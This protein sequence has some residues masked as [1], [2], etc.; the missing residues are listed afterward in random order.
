MGDF[1]TEVLVGQYD[2]DEPYEA[3]KEPWAVEL[4]RVWLDKQT[5]LDSSA[6]D[7]HV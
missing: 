5:R 6:I 7:E 1:F 2:A 4:K 3:E